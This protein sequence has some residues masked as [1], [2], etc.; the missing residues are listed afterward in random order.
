M[1]NFFSCVSDGAGQIL[2]FD[3]P[4]RQLFLQ[5]KIKQESP[6]SHTSIADY[7]GF[8]GGKEDG[9]NKYEYNPLTQDFKI[10]QLNTTDDSEIV[11]Q[12]MLDM[13]WKMI[14]EPLIVKSIINPFLVKRISKTPTEQELEW[15]KQW[16]SMRQSVGASVRKLVRQSVGESV[17]TSV[18][19]S[20]RKLVGQS[21]WKLV[22]Q[23]VWQS[24][25][26]SVWES[27]RTSVGESVGA[28][29]RAYSSSFFDIQFLHDFTPCVKLFESG[30]VPSF[31]GNIW[32][33][34]SGPKAGIIF[35]GK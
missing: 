16:T 20:V 22:G 32:R 8:V 21:V 17:G 26:Q 10:D 24:V 25:G 19:E 27:V 6:D 4:E 35:E 2:Y 18:G 5:G 34:H 23:S 9:L 13:D 1:C 30:L 11:K 3:W 33:L 12:M 31:D 7:H 28:S 29:V 15:L 14:V